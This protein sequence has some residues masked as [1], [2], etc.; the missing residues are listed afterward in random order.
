[1]VVALA[2]VLMSTLFFFKHDN[3]YVQCLRLRLNVFILILFQFIVEDTLHVVFR[4]LF[5]C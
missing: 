1:M 2:L 3:S 4:V 5:D